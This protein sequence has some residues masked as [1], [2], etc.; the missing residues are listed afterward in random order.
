VNAN[1]LKMLT[2]SGA[3]EGPGYKA[4]CSHL[5]RLVEKRQFY[6]CGM[7]YPNNFV[8]PYSMATTIHSGASCLEES[9]S[10]LV[11]Y[12][13]RKQ[14]PNGGWHNQLWARMDHT[15]SSAWALNALMTLGDPRNSVHRQAVQAGLRYLMNQAVRDSNGNIFWRGQVYFAAI[16][17]ARFPIVWRSSAYTTAL[18][19]K[20]LNQADRWQ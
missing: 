9:R 16:F 12:I 8:L 10:D 1:V 17:A 20:A 7:Y 5:N 15:Q 6:D 3:T 2:F 4:A 19:L 18:V 11:R 13:L 14:Q